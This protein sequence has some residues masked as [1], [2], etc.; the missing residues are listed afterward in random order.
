VLKGLEEAH[1]FALASLG[2]P[3]GVAIIEAMSLG[4]PVAVSGA[5]G[6]PGLVSDGQDGLLVP[7]ADATANGRRHRTDCTGREFGR[8]ACKLGE[9]ARR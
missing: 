1:V 3:L 2:E 8:K 9:S 4:T 5:G 7:P 6:V